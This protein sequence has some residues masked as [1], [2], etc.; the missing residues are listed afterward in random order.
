MV[1]KSNSFIIYRQL[2]AAGIK[3]FDIQKYFSTHHV[4]E[5]YGITGI[6]VDDNSEVVFHIIDQ[7]KFALKVVKYG[8]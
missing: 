5:N 6:D 2:R 4:K 3:V 8:L 1:Y 7:K